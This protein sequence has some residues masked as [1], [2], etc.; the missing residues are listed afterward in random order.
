M[1]LYWIFFFFFFFS[2]LKR[3]KILH[4]S[5]DY[6]LFFFKNYGVNSDIF[7]ILIIYSWF[8]KFKYTNKVEEDKLILQF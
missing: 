5:H 6:D 8:L 7:Q 3:K 4:F 2:K 1:F